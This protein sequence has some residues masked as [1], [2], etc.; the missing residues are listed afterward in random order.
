MR[1]PTSNVYH[2]AMYLHHVLNEHT[3]TV[4]RMHDVANDAKSYYDDRIPARVID[5]RNAIIERHGFTVDEWLSI[6]DSAGSLYF[7]PTDRMTACNRE[8]RA[9]F[10]NVPHINVPPHGRNYIHALVS[11]AFDRHVLMRDETRSPYVYRLNPEY[12][13]NP[14][15]TF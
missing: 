13:D 2:I 4:A 15:F 3:F 5:A 8:I 12:I 9:L 11:N 10:V 7:A 1:Y 6:V 14:R